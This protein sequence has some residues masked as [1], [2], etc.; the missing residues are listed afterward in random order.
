MNDTIEV[1][2]A[3]P[4]CQNR[5]MLPRRRGLA[6]IMQRGHAGSSCHMLSRMV[7]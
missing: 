1:D 4:F 6:E 5:D 7:V 3:S 2:I